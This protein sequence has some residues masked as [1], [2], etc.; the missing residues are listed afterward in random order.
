MSQHLKSVCV[1]FFRPDASAVAAAIVVDDDV[2][3]RCVEL[4]SLS[5][6]YNMLS[7]SANRRKMLYEFTR[8]I[9][10]LCSRPHTLTD[11]HLFLLFYDDSLFFVSILLVRF[12]FVDFSVTFASII[13]S[14]VVFVI[15]FHILTPETNFFN[16]IIH[17]AS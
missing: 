6:S 15:S 17:F 13:L 1:F 9:L 16:V 12:C 14:I 4:F 7:I 11:A 2:G 3:R 10:D 8:T 5:H